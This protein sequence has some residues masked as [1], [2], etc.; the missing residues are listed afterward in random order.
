MLLGEITNIF[1]GIYAKP[2]IEGDVFYIQARHFS[3]EGIFDSTVNPDLLYTDKLAKHLL[4]KDDILLA[5]KGLNN[6]AVAY[7]D[8][9]GKAVASS[10]FLVI[11]INQGGILP[12]FLTWYLNHPLAQS[13]FINCS[14][15]TALPCITKRIVENLEITIPT[16]EK[17]RVILKIHELR[18]KEKQI[19]TSIEDLK[20]T[21]IQQHLFNALK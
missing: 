19:K 21:Q 8:E 13:Y 9:I 2:D 18:L 6:F 4:Q 5:S 10:M 11:R 7:N 12:E 3:K 14:K 1:S 20:E 17:Q 15:G 16:L